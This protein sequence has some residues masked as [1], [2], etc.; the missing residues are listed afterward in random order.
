MDCVSS[1][2]GTARWARWQKL[3]L[4][5]LIGHEWGSVL[6]KRELRVMADD[7][8]SV[9]TSVEVMEQVV[10]EQEVYHHRVRRTVLE[11]DLYSVEKTKTYRAVAS[12][13]LVPRSG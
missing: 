11:Q 6:A 7:M 13:L 5:S 8:L 1:A 3:V 2:W 9:V 12:K 10:Q 4:L